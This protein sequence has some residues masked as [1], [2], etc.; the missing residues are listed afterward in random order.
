MAETFNNAKAALTTSAASVYQA[1]NNASTDRAVVI[2]LRCVNVDGTN[3]A[4][5]FAYVANSSDVEQIKLAHELSLPADS[6]LELAGTSNIILLQGE[7][8]FMS[9]SA[10]SVIEVFV[11]SLEIT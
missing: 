5:V 6:V 4:N 8:I 2:S 1:P 3:A 7:K 9:A 11:S 10:N